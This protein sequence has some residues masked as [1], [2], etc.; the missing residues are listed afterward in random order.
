MKKQILEILIREIQLGRRR[1]WR[2]WGNKRWECAWISL[3]VIDVMNIMLEMSKVFIQVCETHIEVWFHGIHPS[4]KIRFH[5]THVIKH[6]SNPWRFTFKGLRAILWSPFTHCSL[7]S[8][9]RLNLLFLWLC[10]L[11]LIFLNFLKK[12]FHIFLITKIMLPHPLFVLRGELLG[13]P[14]ESI[15]KK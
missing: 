14:Y 9:R 4:V 10:F 13:I 2:R 15:I 3:L 1:G 7:F 5:Q 11:T 6:L 8:R 12:C